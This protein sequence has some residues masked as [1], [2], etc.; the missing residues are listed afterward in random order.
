MDAV[1]AQCFLEEIADEYEVSESEG[2]FVEALTVCI[3]TILKRFRVVNLH[4][5]EPELPQPKQWKAAALQTM[6][7]NL[8]RRIC[9]AYE[10]RG[11]DAQVCCNMPASPL[12]RD[13]SAVPVSRIHGP[14][15]Y[16]FGGHE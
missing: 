1:E 7:L 12:I 15:T 2:R 14:H 5:Q 16:T 13:W 6:N 4:K 11:T 8:L 10:L 3:N 9:V